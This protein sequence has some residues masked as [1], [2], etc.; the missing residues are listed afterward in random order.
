MKIITLGATGMI[1]NA[2]FSLL[3]E[4]I[5]WE[6]Y[7]TF[8][9]KEII[10]LFPEKFRSK[11]IFLNNA[12]DKYECIQ[13]FESINPDV[14]V[15]CI[16]ITKHHPESLD[17]DN[18]YNL[19]AHF[20]Q[21]L[22]EHCFAN[23]Y[24]LIHVSTDCVFNGRIGNYKEYDT[25]NASDD[26]GKSKALGEIQNYNNLT[27]RTSTIGH[28]LQSHFGLLEWFLRQSS[29]CIGY[30]N[31]FFSGLTNIEFGLILRNIVIPNKS[32]TG[33]Y[34]IG[35]PAINKYSLLELIAL[36]YSKKILINL[37]ESI[38]IDRSLN[39]DYFT[40]STG[41]KS[42][43]WIKMIKKMFMYHQEKYNV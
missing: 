14:I 11:L 24:R 43:T 13:L 20:P 2:V 29:E 19:N 8:R 34:N 18:L 15:N 23:R 4:N 38:I 36:I 37:D 1:G 12:L 35:G 21:W 32:L 26:Y 5:N 10:N 9:N 7:G 41:Y 25:K 33:L 30:K 39:S 6:V 27:L 28:E 3:S 40:Y 16:G 42:P 31:A 22:S 17:L